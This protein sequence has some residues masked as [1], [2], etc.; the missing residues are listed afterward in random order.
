M[1]DATAKKIAA[2]KVIVTKGSQVCVY[3][4]MM[5]LPESDCPHRFNRRTNDQFRLLK[6]SI[7]P[8]QKTTLPARAA[9]PLLARALKIADRN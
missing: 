4:S 2:V 6:N 1:N 5:P 9:I 8:E 3:S 7:R